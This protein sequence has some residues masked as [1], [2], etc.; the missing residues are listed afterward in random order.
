MRRSPEPEV[1][2]T[3]RCEREGRVVDGSRHGHLGGRALDA[4]V[5]RPARAV[6]VPCSP[7]PSDARPTFERPQVVTRP[8][9]QAAAPGVLVD[10]AAGVGRRL[11]ARLRDPR[12]RRPAEP[13]A[14]DVEAAIGEEAKVDAAP[15]M[16]VDRAR[17]RRRAV[18]DDRHDRGRD[19]IGVGEAFWRRSSA[20]RVCPTE[21]LMV[22]PPST[23]SS[24]PVTYRDASLARKTATSPI[25]DGVG[26]AAERDPLLVRRAHLG[27][28]RRRVQR[29]VRRAG[30]EG[31]DRDPVRRELE[32]RAFSSAR[33]S[34]PS[35][36]M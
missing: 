23:S 13:G 6:Y 36:S 34:R 32:R 20:A 7:C 9:P 31:V 28:V 24:C 8:P 14:A 22:S 30:R 2:T 25:S 11:L 29:R 35:R 1:V 27:R 19:L 4:Q 3:R 12:E 17:S 21:P 15:D 26:D 18:G 10:E 16:D 33:R 5:G